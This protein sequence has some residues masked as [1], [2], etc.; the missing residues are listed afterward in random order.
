MLKV[1]NLDIRLS[2]L[3]NLKIYQLKV[4]NKALEQVPRCY[5]VAFVYF[6][7]VFASGVSAFMIDFEHNSAS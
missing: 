1:S 3:L 2:L 5:S 7:Q 4:N 6:R